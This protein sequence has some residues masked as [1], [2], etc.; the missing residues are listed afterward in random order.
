MNI[1]FIFFAC[2]LLFSTYVFGQDVKLWNSIIGSAFLNNQSYVTLEK[3]CDEAGGRLLGSPQ[4]EKAMNILKEELGKIGCE[5]KF[6]KF[7]VPGWVRGNDQVIMK[8]PTLR[9][10]Q[11]VALGY[12]DSTPTFS[13]NLIYA[14]Y[15]FES[16]YSDINAEG[17]IVLVSQGT[18]PGKEALL[19]YEAIDIAAG[20]GAKAILFINDEQGTLNLAGTGNF[21]GKPTK[22]PAYS[23]TYEEG[24][25]MERLLAKNKPVEI[26]LTT[27]SYC[28]E[29]ETSNVVVSFKG[30]VNSKIVVGAHFDSWD[31][32]QGGVDNGIGSAILFDVARLLKAYS[33][34][35]YYSVDLV[36]FNG[37]ELGLWGSKKYTEMHAQD[38]IIAMINMDMTGSPTG[39]NVMGFDE[40][41]PFFKKLASNLNGF[42]L[43]SGVV[44]SPG[45]NSDHMWFMFKGIPTFSLL[46]H[47]DENMYKYYHERGD[48]F[49]KV[50]K[51]YLTEAS[52]VVSILVSELANNKELKYSIRTDH[53]MVEL[54]K[55]YGL[56]KRLKRQNEWIYKED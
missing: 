43:T 16:D 40:F 2:F 38:S 34:D 9:K 22:I 55:H 12:V 49:D 11:G 15:G 36:W 17:K 21:I 46:A 6:E 10:L 39:F 33:A 23:L 47:L 28:K 3:I 29:V 30:K 5:A 25:W 31:L 4:N 14:N 42:N 52:A 54:F 18:P 1:K 35:N 8:S 51:K 41:I 56:D 45:T 7:N 48:T 53:Q 20:Y 50:N 19:R 26:E 27:K 44:S 24:K 32:G 13:A 37:E